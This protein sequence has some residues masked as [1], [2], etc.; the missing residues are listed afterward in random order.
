MVG[1]SPRHKFAKNEQK[2]PEDKAGHPENPFF[3]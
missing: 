1:M 3:L 2:R